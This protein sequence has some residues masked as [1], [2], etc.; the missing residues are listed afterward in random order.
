MTLLQGQ[1]PLLLGRSDGDG[2]CRDLAMHRLDGYRSPLPPIRSA[3]MRDPGNWP[4]RY[5]SWLDESPESPLHDGRWELRE[6]REFPPYVWFSEEFVRDWPGGSL[7]LY[8]GGG[9]NGVLPLRRL[10]APDDP[11]VKAYRKHVRDGTLAPVLLWRVTF[12]DGWLILDG[13]DRAL[14]ALEEGRTPPCVV[15][16]RVPDDENDEVT[17]TAGTRT[18]PHPGGPRAWDEIAARVMFECPRD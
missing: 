1:R 8:C 15:L 6:R 13:H 12:L 5:A 14:A 11:R 16:T 7:E 3:L 18:W 17:E 10:S 9:W 2:C 4:H